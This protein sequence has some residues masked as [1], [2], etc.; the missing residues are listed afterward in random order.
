MSL[1]ETHEPLIERVQD[2]ELTSNT[3]SWPVRFY[4]N[5]TAQ[6]LLNLTKRN[7]HGLR[8]MFID[9]MTAVFWDAYSV[10]HSMVAHWLRDQGYPIPATWAYQAL[11]VDPRRDPPV[12]YVDDDFIDTPVIQRL[13]SSFQL[14]N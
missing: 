11:V 4:F 9:P 2:A 1:I 5:A 13:A 10:H 8:G 7:Q 3:G 14:M 6:S 12:L